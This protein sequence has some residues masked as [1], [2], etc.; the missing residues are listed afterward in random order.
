MSAERIGRPPPAGG[1]SPASRAATRSSSAV[2]LLLQDG[3]VVLVGIV[4]RPERGRRLEPAAQA[5]HV[6]GLQ[7]PAPVAPNR[8]QQAALHR[9]AHLL[10]AHADEVGNLGNGVAVHAGDGFDFEGRK[11]A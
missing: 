2:D 5:L 9:L 3:Q 7:E 4:D 6:H 1:G 10:A 11:P 8:G